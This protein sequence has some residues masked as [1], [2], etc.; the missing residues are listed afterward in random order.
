[1]GFFKPRFPDVDP[2][3]FCASHNTGGSGRN[4]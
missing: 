2:G 4:E 3:E 1:M